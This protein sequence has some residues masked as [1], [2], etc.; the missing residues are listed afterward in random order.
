MSIFE[1]K[2]EKGENFLIPNEVD[3]GGEAK[4]GNSAGNSEG[5]GGPYYK[6]NERLQFAIF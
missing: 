3:H 4:S 2:R 6:S 1:N 5:Q